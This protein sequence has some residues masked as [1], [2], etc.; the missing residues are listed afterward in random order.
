M[1]LVY[2]HGD[3]PP[4]LPTHRVLRG[5]PTGPGLLDELR[6]LGSIEPVPGRAALVAAMTTLTLD[7]DAGNGSGTGTG[8]LGVLSGDRAAILRLDHAAIAERLPEQL[9][10][11]SRGLDVN[12]LSVVIERLYGATS[13]VLAD[14]GRLWYVKDAAEATRQ[15]EDGTASTCFLL[16][17]MPDGAITA[18]ARAGEVMPQKS[19]YFHPKAPAGL[20]FSPM[21]W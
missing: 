18:V 21:E 13:D 12:A 9:S 2:P 7:R 11:P 19:T 15:V 1:V 6:T 16:D 8:R 20:A 5:E 3:A 4:A 17:R 10:A 14:G